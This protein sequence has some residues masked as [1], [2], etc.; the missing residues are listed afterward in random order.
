MPR[1]VQL[2]VRIFIFIEPSRR[3]KRSIQRNILRIVKQ[4]Q[5]GIE[6]LVDGYISYSLR[7]TSNALQTVDNV[8]QSIDKIVSDIIN[9]IDN[10]LNKPNE[11]TLDG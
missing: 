2:N 4:I 3:K 9:D 1:Y 11:Y 10:R 6:K 5:G 8:H 7:G